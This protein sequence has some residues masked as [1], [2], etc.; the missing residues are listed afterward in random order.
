MK[1]CVVHEA[2]IA[3]IYYVSHILNIHSAIKRQHK[4]EGKEN[5][6]CLIFSLLFSLPHLPKI[7]IKNAYA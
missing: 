6:S 5:V 7:K 4:N 2:F 3:A 1:R